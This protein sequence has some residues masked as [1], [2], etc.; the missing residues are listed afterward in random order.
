MSCQL[1]HHTMLNHK[2]VCL[3]LFQLKKDF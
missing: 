1:Y 3:D 2:T